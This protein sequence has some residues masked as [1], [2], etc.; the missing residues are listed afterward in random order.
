MI[1]GHP[2]GVCG[3]RHRARSCPRGAALGFLGA[4]MI[5]TA[6]LATPLSAQAISGMLVD[7]DTGAP[8]EGASVILLSRA[9][10]RLDWRLSNAAGRFDFRMPGAGTFLLQAERIG[11]ARVLSEPIPIDRGV[12]VVYRLEVPV[13]EVMLAGI[14]VESSRR[15]EVRPGQGESTARV[16]EEARKALEATSR[17]SGRGIYRYEIRRFERELD[18]RGRRVRSEQSR[19]ERQVLASPFVSLNVEDLLENGFARADGEGRDYYAPDADVLLSDAFLDTHCMSLAEGD[20]EAEGLLGL[21]F[22]PTRDRGV[23]DISGVLWVDP[24]DGELQ[25]LD[26]GYEFLDVPNSNRLGGRIQFH[27]LPNGTWIVREWHIRMPLLRASL[28]GGRVRPRLVGIREEGGSVLRVTNLRDELV[29]DSGAAIIRG[30]VLDSEDSEPVEAVVVLLSDGRRVT[31]DED[32]R[33]Q[34]ADL[35]G[36]SYDLRVFDPVL[37]PLSLS[38]EP[39]FLDLSPGDVASVPLRFPSRSR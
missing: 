16:W 27:G 4:L 26:Y 39:V 18:A 20:D 14:E 38:A 5:A 30:V 21:S 19:I 8:I 28:R 7:A 34:F 32:G 22:E 24:V 31:T 25:W 23:P 11:H 13:E 17:T 36:G 15:C 9:G 6:P 2:S 1:A 10:E 37:D 29:L 35:V 12:T 33:F 3:A